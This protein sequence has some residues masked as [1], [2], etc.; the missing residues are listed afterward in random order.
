[1]QIPGRHV[2]RIRLHTV[3]SERK[4]SA[5]VSVP[6][7]PAV[8]QKRLQEES[9]DVTLTESQEETSFVSL[10]AELLPILTTEERSV[11]LFTPFLQME[12]T[13]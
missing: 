4:V 10:P 13:R 1:M 12:T 3:N 9:V 5:A 7:V 2:L 6:W 8:L 11:I